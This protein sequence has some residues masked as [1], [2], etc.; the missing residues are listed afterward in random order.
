MPHTDRWPVTAKPEITAHDLSAASQQRAFSKRSTVIDLAHT[1]HTATVRI[2]LSG[3]SEGVSTSGLPI[4]HRVAL[5][6]SHHRSPTSGWR[7]RRHAQRPAALR[8][9]LGYS[10]E[11]LRIL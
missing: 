8:A 5:P 1:S 11:P 6:Y 10:R 2:Q 7:A 9:A 4:R 3:S